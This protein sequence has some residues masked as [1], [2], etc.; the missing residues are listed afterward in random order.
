[1]EV[2]HK[3]G[4]LNWDELYRAVYEFLLCDQEHLE[5]LCKECH[6][7]AEECEKQPQ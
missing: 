4:V 7:K 6:K 2:H 5:T 3:E 1:M